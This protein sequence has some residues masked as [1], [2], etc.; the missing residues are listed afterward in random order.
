M[1]AAQGEAHEPGPLLD[2]L[3]AGRARHRLL[4]NDLAEVTGLDPGYVWAG[5]LRVATD[6]ASQEQPLCR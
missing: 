2:L 5:T 3:L 4:G 1:L 6:E